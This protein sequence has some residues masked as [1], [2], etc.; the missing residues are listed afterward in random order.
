MSAQVIPGSTVT[1]MSS[2]LIS[3]IRSSRPVSTSSEF[4]VLAHLREYAA[5]GLADTL[6]FVDGIDGYDYDWSLN[7]TVQTN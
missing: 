7:D 2:S 4:G 1:Y 6:R 5:P 3:T